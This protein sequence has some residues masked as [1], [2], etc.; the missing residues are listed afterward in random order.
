MKGNLHEG[1]KTMA[2]KGVDKSMSLPKSPTVSQD[3]VRKST[4]PNQKSLGPRNA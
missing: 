2:P 1:M 3:A 4:A